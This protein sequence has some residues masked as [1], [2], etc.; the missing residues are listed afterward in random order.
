MGY[1]TLK[2]NKTVYYQSFVEFTYIDIF[3][4]LKIDNLI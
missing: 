4:N 2:Y 1:L 3:K